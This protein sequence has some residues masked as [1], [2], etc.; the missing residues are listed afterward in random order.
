MSLDGYIAGPNG[1]ADWIV[2]NPEIDFRAVFN[3]FNEPL[4]TMV[5]AGKATIPGMKTY[6][7]SS[8]LLQKDYPDV[9]I[10][11][12]NHQDVLRSFR[13]DRGKIFGYSAAA[14]CFAVCS[15]P[16]WSTP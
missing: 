1:E 9:T 13:T 12:S 2:M 14:R 10:L 5:R 8:T 4:K 6:V 3:Q 11:G 16:G 7:F 15:T